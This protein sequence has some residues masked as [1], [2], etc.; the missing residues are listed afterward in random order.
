MSRPRFD[1]RF[2]VAIAI[3][4]LGVSL[5]FYG[6]G[7]GL[8]QV[9][10]D[11]VPLKRAWM[12]WG[13]GPQLPFD[14][15][16][17]FFNYPS[18]YLYIQLLGQAVL[19]GI[20]TAIGSVGSTIDFQ[21]LYVLDKTPF[22]LM[23]R[24]ITA[25]LGSATIPLVYLIGRRIGGPLTA[26]GA[27][28][29]LT[30]NPEHIAESKLVSVDVPLTF[31]VTLTLLYCLRLADRPRGKNYVRAGLYLGLGASIKYTA[32]I[33]A[34]PIAVAHALRERDRK[35]GRLRRL[36]PALAVLLGAAVFF[37]TS[38]FVILDFHQFWADFSYERAHM[39]AGHF[40]ATGSP[41]W[42]YYLKTLGGPILGWPAL[43]L[44]IAGMVF[45]ARRR[46]PWTVILLSFAAPY[47]VMIS[48]WNMQA[49]R[50]L[51]PVV[52][53]FLLFAVAAVNRVLERIRIPGSLPRVWAAGVIAFFVLAATPLGAFPKLLNRIK[54]DTRTEARRLIE[55]QVPSGGFIVS[56]F[57]GPEL[58]GPL[59]YWPLPGGLKDRIRVQNVPFFAFMRIPM[60]QARPEESAVF[61]DLS[62]YREVDL[63][64]ISGGVKARY[65]KDPK[66]FAA[67]I[68]FYETLEHRFRKVWD[69]EPGDMTGPE[70]VVYKNP[71]YDEPFAYRKTQP[72]TPELRPAKITGKEGEFFY[73]MG[74]NY[75]TFG[76]PQQG[77]EC[78]LRGFDYPLMS[79]EL[80]LN[81]AFGVIRCY[82]STDRT[83]DAYAFM[84]RVAPGL[85]PRDRAEL[86]ALRRS[87][88]RDHPRAP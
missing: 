32:M 31:F 38:P 29:L 70:I 6:L 28:L 40:G 17:H 25:L 62:L 12:M 76:Y 74:L 49:E 15:N 39:E 52:P 54:P 83:E 63:I 16:P 36:G 19:Y 82:L 56:E 79:R 43:V 57:L 72:A 1:R 69:F 88:S 64:V 50:Y 58:F 27:A 18:L 20:L 10:E 53:V 80:P 9:Y 59:D 75:E 77:L 48:L 26:A 46:R 7:W 51:M 55:A 37:A 68:A 67:Q 81:L 8:P 2:F 65:L 14:L 13:W 34:V 35:S 3:L 60:F 71:G 85:P 47:L 87:M 11:A 66:R 61:Y 22:Y 73:A 21:L 4:A 45:L 23:G 5:R 86:E 44:G 30:L 33:L 42:I 78:Y 24:G 84:D 41:T